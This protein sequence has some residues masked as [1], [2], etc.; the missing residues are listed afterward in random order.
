MPRPVKSIEEAVRAFVKSGQS[1]MV[2]GFGRGGVPFSVID[3]IADHPAEYRDFILYKNDANEPGLGIGRLLENRQAAKLCTTHIGL[4]PAFI[5]QMNAKEIACEL[6]PQGIFAEKIRAGGAGIPAFLSDIGLGTVYAQGKEKTVLD[7]KEYILERAF[8]GDV[9]LVCAD[10][11]D[12]FGNCWWEGSNRNMCVIMATA[13]R[14]TIVEA[15]EIVKAGAIA[16]ED[17]HLPGIFV[18]AV[19][20]SGPRRHREAA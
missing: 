11:V 7:G 4:N 2:G 19:V 13:C 14:R 3:Y 8:T 15:K 5:A 17:A 20:K 18:S 1:L 16:P 12:A 9:A 10:R 6:M